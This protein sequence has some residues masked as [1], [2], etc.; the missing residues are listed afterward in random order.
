MTNNRENKMLSATDH[1][2]S[3][4]T[5]ELAKVL[6]DTYQIP[7]RHSVRNATTEDIKNVCGL[8]LWLYEQVLD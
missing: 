5:Q 6:G 3:T 1:M 7:R 4:E 2:Y 8:P